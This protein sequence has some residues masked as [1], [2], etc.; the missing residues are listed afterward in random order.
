MHQRHTSPSP[1]WH[2]K[3]LCS[4]SVFRDIDTCVRITTITVDSSVVSI[5][6]YVVVVVVIFIKDDVKIEP[7]VK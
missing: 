6:E 3:Y 4:C 7:S 1:S 2:S 5:V